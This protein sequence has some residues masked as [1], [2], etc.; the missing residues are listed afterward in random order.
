MMDAMAGPMKM[1]G[2]MRPEGLTDRERAV[3]SQFPNLLSFDKETYLHSGNVSNAVS[4]GLGR[5]AMLM[6]GQDAWVMP[7]EQLAAIGSGLWSGDL[8]GLDLPNNP[9]DP[10]FVPNGDPTQPTGSFISLSHGVTRNFALKCNDCH[11]PS[12]V[13]DFAALSY[14]PRQAE[15]LQTLL[16]KV[17]FVVQQK[18]PE[19]L[20]LRWTAI[21][22]RTY[23]VVATDDLNTRTW[24]P[25]TA[26]IRGVSQWYERVVPASLLS[27]NRQIFFRVNEV[28]P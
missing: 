7:P 14:T 13:L 6:S 12:G 22:G 5:L 1:M 3:L 28:V 9:A 11:S 8:L 4:V 16:R 27:T 15:H 10:T 17:Q 24:W 21:P 20:K 2:F 19:G 18:T 23:Q 25:V 26:T